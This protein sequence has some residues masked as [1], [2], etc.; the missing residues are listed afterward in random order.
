MLFTMGVSLY[1]SRIVL[2]VLGIEDYGLYSIIGGIV[3]LLAVVSSTMRNAT[4]RFITFE[5]GRGD[6]ERV[7]S[8]FSMSMIAHF[9]VSLVILLLGETIG[10]W[11]VTT[12]LNIPAGRE[13]AALFIYQVSLLT[14]VLTL[15]RSPYDASVISHEKM[16]FFAVVSILDAVLKL[17]I[18]FLLYA[19]PFDKL[20]FYSCLILCS[21]IIIYICYHLYCRHKFDTCFFRLAIDK[22]YLKQLFSFLGW[23][24]LGSSA[25]LGTQQAGNL[26]INK[27]L[28]VSINAA[29]G[30]ANQVSGAI[31]SF[32][33]NF[34]V[35][36]TPQIVKLYSQ[37]RQ[38][39]FH[40][41]CNSS[42]L[43]SYYI[44]FVVSFPIIVNIDYVLRL[45][46]VEV[47]QYAGIFC[48]LLILYSLI[49]A[50]QT[51][52]WVGINASGNIK[53]YEIWLSVIL[54]LNIPFAILVL[55]LGWPPYWV[56]IV[57]VILN[58]ITAMIRCIH[59]KIQL[60]FPIRNY[61][62]NVVSRALLVS[63]SAI[64]VWYVIPH[65]WA[66]QSFWAFL[67]FCL[68][69]VVFISIIVFAI[70]IGKSERAVVLA[71]IQRFLP[72]NV[73][74]HD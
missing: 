21:N 20:I 11:Y 55:R 19:A 73:I 29:Y 67:L 70:G 12:Q 28:G 3:V 15:M 1:T 8:A 40:K 46:L 57:R 61:L 26:I 45:W 35:A 39:E 66:R 49:D 74:K 17:L 16:T 53:L 54:I 65:E 60:R 50:I 9:I 69:S 51:P 10:L 47:P 71:Y 4:Q 30:I 56:L 27:F 68:I 64:L 25:T 22:A 62:K 59:V 43:L 33:A 13:H 34:Q 58:L 7:C 44:L 6:S 23:S 72:F 52:F 37:N 5:L 14:T 24:L 18:A 41:L 36:Y 48:S 63:L 2:D 31:Y 38:E 32:A 42:A